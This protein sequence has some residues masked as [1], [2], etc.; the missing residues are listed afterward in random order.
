MTHSLWKLTLHATAMCGVSRVTVSTKKTQQSIPMISA[1]LCVI[2]PYAPSAS[3]V[4]MLDRSLT[5]CVA[6]LVPPASKRNSVAS[7]KTTTVLSVVF[8]LKFKCRS[9]GRLMIQTMIVTKVSYLSPKF[10]K[11]SVRTFNTTAL[12]FGAGS[13]AL[14]PS[15]TSTREIPQ[16]HPACSIPPAPLLVAKVL[17][18]TTHP[19][20]PLFLPVPIFLPHLLSPLF[21]VL[22]PE[23][24]LF[25]CLAPLPP[26][27][28][29]LQLSPPFPLL[30]LLLLVPTIA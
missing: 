23:P 9:P 15:P 28:T 24:S 18:M 2:P 16:T 10:S 26:L 21:R 4:V 11:A 3:C 17:K 12:I 1:A 27:L 8:H 22:L 6:I 25:P 7:K 30:S 20:L 19:F 5:A 14:M 13:T 29:L